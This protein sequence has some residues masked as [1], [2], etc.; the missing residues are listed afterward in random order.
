M[1]AVKEIAP[2]FHAHLEFQE[3]IC[4][5]AKGLLAWIKRWIAQRSS[6]DRTH[7][8]SIYFDQRLDEIQNALVVASTHGG[9]LLVVGTAQNF[10]EEGTHFAVE[11]FRG[12]LDMQDRA[13]SII[14]KVDDKRGGMYKH[15]FYRT[16]L[17]QSSGGDPLAAD[18]SALREFPGDEDTLIEQ[19]MESI[20]NADL[21]AMIGNILMLAYDP[22][23]APVEFISVVKQLLQ[24]DRAQRLL[25]LIREQGVFHVVNGKVDVTGK[26]IDALATLVDDYT[27]FELV[28]CGRISTSGSKFDTYAYI[29]D[30]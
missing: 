27:M 22:S 18:A 14:G 30:A 3:Y 4:H 12:A 15:Y 2:N 6:Y 21:E 10:D 28:D 20:P 13:S 11:T 26:G 24:R 9:K 5:D 1:P 19:M 25:T 17:E 7:G 8:G 29:A 23:F 16:Y